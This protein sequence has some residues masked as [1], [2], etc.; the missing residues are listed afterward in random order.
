MGGVD[1]CY[2]RYVEFGTPDPP[3]PRLV[4]F[5]TEG[6]KKIFRYV[7]RGIRPRLFLGRS[8]EAEQKRFPPDLRDAVTGAL[9]GGR[10]A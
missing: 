8:I 1:V 2:A 4:F 7:R 3:R 5:G 9:R 10:S 6:G